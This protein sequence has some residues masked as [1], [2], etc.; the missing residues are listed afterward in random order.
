[1]TAITFAGT[2]ELRGRVAELAAVF[3][4]IAETRMAGLPIVNPRLIVEAVGFR[5]VHDGLAGV[6]VTPWA[7]SLMFLPRDPTLP[8]GGLGERDKMSRVF[9]AGAVEMLV[10]R[11]DGVGWYLSASLFS[12][13]DA[14]S[15][16]EA[17]RLAAEGAADALFRIPERDAPEPVGRR[18][19]FRRLVS[20]PPDLRETLE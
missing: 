9:P 4:R 3:E 15:D 16:P 20:A 11:E 19:M 1:M 5:P 17:A 13:M 10:G 14:F 18:E 6:L 2:Q 8:I 7:M 12:P